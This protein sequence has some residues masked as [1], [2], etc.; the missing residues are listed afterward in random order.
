MKRTIIVLLLLL[1]ILPMGVLAADYNETHGVSMGSVATFT[2]D[3]QGWRFKMNQDDTI[4]GISK[5]ANSKTTIGYITTD[6]AG[7]NILAQANFTGGNLVATLPVPLSVTK[8]STYYLV[9]KEAVN[10]S[11]AGATSCSVNHARL[12]W[13]GC[14]LNGGDYASQPEVF[15]GLILNNDTVVPTSNNSISVIVKNTR[16]GLLIS[17]FNFNV[18]N[19]TVTWIGLCSGTIC[20]NTTFNITNGI[21]YF[22][23]ISNSTYFNTTV[24]A[25]NFTS[26][27]T[28]TNITGLTF[29][30]ILNLSAYNIVNGSNIQGLCAQVNNVT[31]N[32]TACTLSSPLIIY[33]IIGNIT[34]TLY[35]IGSGDNNQ[36]NAL[37]INQS[38]SYG[39]FNNSGDLETNLSTE[40]GF[41]NITAT[42]LYTIMGINSF[43]STNNLVTN[44][45]TTGSILIPAN[46]GSQFINTNVLGNFSINQ[47]CILTQPLA[48]QNCV[49]NGFYDEL[50]RFNATKANNSPITNFTVSMTNLS[51]GSGI[52]NQSTTN[53][54]VFIPALQG[55]TYL[56]AFNSSG[57]STTNAYLNANSSAFNYTFSRVLQS[58]TIYLNFYDAISLAPITQNV[59]VLFVNGGTSFTNIT[60]KSSLN[61]SNLTAGTWTLTITSSGYI[62][63]QYLATI[64]DTTSSTANVYM[65]QGTQ[66]V[67]FTTIDIISSQA[68]VGSTIQQYT[69]VNGTQ[70][71]IDTSTTDIT[72]SS[73]FS[74]T[75]AIAYT[76]VISAPGYTNRTFTLNPIIFSTYN[77]KL[78]SPLTLNFSQ[79]YQNV[80]MTYSPTL[81]YANQTNTM[82]ILFSSI[83]NSFT[84]YSYN[85]RYPGGTKTG[86]GSTPAGQTFIV[87]FNV[88]GATIGDNV[89]ITLDYNNGLGNHEFNYSHNIIIGPPPMT[90]AANAGNT[91]GLGLIERALVGTIIILIIAGI[92][93]LAISPIAG[94]FVAMFL[95]GLFIKMGFWEWWLAGISFL[96]GFVI[97]IRR[98]E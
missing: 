22:T 61:I 88:T 45:T 78:T 27:T 28:T 62:T 26:N 43:N 68:I 33:N 73:Q 58:N 41:L 52:V 7:A 96:I 63:S 94:L 25:I 29:K 40:Q 80:K 56:F 89:N 30:N 67:I 59:S 79:D 14:V 23:N 82:I 4:K 37:Y 46:N 13:T 51:I 98:T 69:A 15:T 54:T 9:M 66:T 20:T 19:G 60:N 35:D 36:S 38:Y 72:G 49:F 2:S 81:F 85:I 31:H 76:F 65:T 12:N 42:Q 10:G 11:Y 39:A 70:T 50:F 1:L 93:S 84:S 86:S 21:A 83:T 44:T 17:G 97:L 57:Y 77:I 90:F 18:T 87:T 8:G 64:S 16:T 47:T 53:G 92:I 95:M 6:S 48:T 55:Y 5:H 74:Y 3:A 71:L 32:S 75:P 34:I 91:Y 24:S